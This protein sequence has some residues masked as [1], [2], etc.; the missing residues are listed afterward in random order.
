MGETTWT[1]L[2]EG[3][4]YFV[5]GREQHVAAQ[6]T[7]HPALRRVLVEP[8]LDEHRRETGAF[9][10]EI[11]FVVDGDDTPDGVVG[12][13][14]R[15]LLDG[16]LAVLAFSTGYP[17]GLTKTPSVRRPGSV[18][19]SFRHIFFAEPL[20]LGPFGPGAVG[21]PPVL[22]EAILSRSLTDEQFMLLGWFRASLETK[23]YLESCTALLAALEPLANHFPCDA[24]RTEV[25]PKCGAE[26]VLAASATQRVRSFLTTEGGL[27]DLEAK[28]IWDLRNDMAHGRMARTAEQRQAVA[29]LRRG[30][31]SAVARGL[32]ALLGLDHGGT[33]A[34]PLGG[35]SYSD[36]IL[37][38]EYHSPEGAEDGTSE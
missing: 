3:Q 5:L 20:P 18:E 19:G 24:T 36:A 15:D 33:P 16:V 34:E 37:A 1:I 13:L 28:A 14:A 8:V 22:N 32:R 10:L 17:C 23:D 31:V 6:A 29:K 25:C 2:A 21:P 11:D 12:N 26:R 4:G 38:V 9:K 7:P 27:S 35:P 30:L